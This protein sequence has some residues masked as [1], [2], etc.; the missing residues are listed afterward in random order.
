M[1]VEGVVW[2][3]GVVWGTR[4]VCAVHVVKAT[5]HTAL[6]YLSIYVE[7]DEEEAPTPSYFRNM[8]KRRQSGEPG[9]S[10]GVDALC[11]STVTVCVRGR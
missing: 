4:G 2:S 9:V 10:T 6:Y 7:S 11:H 1:C 8:V 5:L 3:Y